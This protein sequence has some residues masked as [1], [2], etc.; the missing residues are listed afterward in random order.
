MK[1]SRTSR[2]IT[3]DSGFILMNVLLAV[4]ALGMTLTALSI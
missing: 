3:E 1:V 4:F 2:E